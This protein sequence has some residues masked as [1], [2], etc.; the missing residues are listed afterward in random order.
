MNK[1]KINHY[2]EILQA[3]KDGKEVQE[4]RVAGG[5]EW[6][7]FNSK[8]DYLITSGSYEY[9]IK[10]EPKVIW[11]SKFDIDNKHTHI[12]ATCMDMSGGDSFAK[13]IEVIE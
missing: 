10:P 2:I 11:V 7:V 9:R 8:N 5:S 3:L 12:K 4:R 6:Y 13:F 1:D